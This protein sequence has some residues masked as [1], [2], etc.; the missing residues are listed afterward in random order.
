MQNTFNQNPNNNQG[1]PTIQGQNQPNQPYM[2][3]EM[4]S[5]NTSSQNLDTS[6]SNKI[7][8]QAILPG[9]PNP[10]QNPPYNNAIPNQAILPGQPNPYQNSP[11]MSTYQSTQGIPLNNYPG[12]TGGMFIQPPQ[13]N[14]NYE[15][16]KNIGEIPHLLFTQPDDNTFLISSKGFLITPIIMICASLP[17]FIIPIVVGDPVMYIMFFFA[18]LA[19][20][21]SICSCINTE[22]SIYFI[23]GQNNITVVK[24]TVCKK[25]NIFYNS[26]E[27][28]RVECQQNFRK[29]KKGLRL[30]Y[31]IVFITTKGPEKIYGV[32]S[33]SSFTPNEI[34]YFLY[35]VNKHIQTK[36]C[37]K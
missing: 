35:V 27:L 31:E 4:K 37:P 1:N 9:Q 22:I 8:N 20:L 23:L 3:Y 13:N 28:L 34:G 36:M 11:Y 26:G 29:R 2:Q 14:I 24:N 6:Y 21:I 32:N 19:V 15:N 25:K 33:A 5:Y 10:Y 18:S 12:Q 30:V 7:S 17:F 16:I